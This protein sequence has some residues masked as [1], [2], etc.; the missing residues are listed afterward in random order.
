MD[1]PIEGDP[2]TDQH[3]DPMGG[4]T[5]NG[6]RR[7][8]AKSGGQQHAR[9]PSNEGVLNVGSPNKYLV[10][11]PEW[12][13]GS[14]FTPWEQ[15][16]A[17][18]YE[19]PDTSDS[20]GDTPSREQTPTRDKGKVID[21]VNFGAIPALERDAKA[22]RRAYEDWQAV[23]RKAQHKTRTEQPQKEVRVA[24]EPDKVYEGSK[25]SKHNTGSSEDEIQ[26]LKDKQRRMTEKRKATE[27]A[28]GEAPTS[29]WR[30]GLPPIRLWAL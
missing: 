21:P 12:I 18:T 14:R 2:M 22:Q 7:V 27:S 3:A 24:S 28:K 8:G 23:E 16:E 9:R 11:D 4:D 17:P 25:A 10:L 13:G 15:R 20:G 30:G 5:W 29:T 6:W 1:D 26:A 19:E